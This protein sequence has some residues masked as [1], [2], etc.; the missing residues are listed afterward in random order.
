[1]KRADVLLGRGTGPSEHKGNRDFRFL[2]AKRVNESYNVTANRRTV[3]RIAEQTVKD[4]MVKRGRFLRRLDKSEHRFISDKTSAPALDDVLNIQVDDVTAVLKTKQAF[5]HCSRTATS[6]TPR[7]V[8]S[9]TIGGIIPP[10]P[11]SS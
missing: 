4:V 3:S 7:A 8:A 5:R 2:I 9:P 1:M 10:P 6:S 11:D